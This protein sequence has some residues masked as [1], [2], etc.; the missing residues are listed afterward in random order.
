MGTKELVVAQAELGP[1]GFKSLP[2]VTTGAGERAG[3][4][5]LILYREYQEQEY[6]SC[7]RAS[8]WAVLR[9]P[10]QLGAPHNLLR[11]L[12]RWP[13]EAEIPVPPMRRRDRGISRGA[14]ALLSVP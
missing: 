10:P 6:A 12:E 13:A 1:V 4:R 9:L 11:R 5:F 7:I 8:S 3:Q 14:G 2:A